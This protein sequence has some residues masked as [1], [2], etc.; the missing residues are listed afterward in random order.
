MERDR[1]RWRIRICTLMMLVVIA[2][3]GV[4]RRIIGVG[5]FIGRIIG[6]NN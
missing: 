6:A 2:A 3:L 5:S 1:P 4:A